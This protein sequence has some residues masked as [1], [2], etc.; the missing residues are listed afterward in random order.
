MYYIPS[1]INPLESQPVFV[2]VCVCVCACVC[3]CLGIAH[4]RTFIHSTKTQIMTNNGIID[5]TLIRM[6]T[7]STEN[8]EKSVSFE[9]THWLAH[10]PALH[11]RSI[12]LRTNDKP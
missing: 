6:V 3:A 8:M 4:T 5:Q 7:G 9:E 12:E 11:F 2:C 10:T 1:V